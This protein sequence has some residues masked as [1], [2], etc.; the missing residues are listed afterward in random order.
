MFV[1]NVYPFS[2]CLFAVMPIQ[3]LSKDEIIFTSAQVFRKRGYNN[4][5]MADLAEA[6]GLTKGI[7]YHHFENKEELM[8]AVLHG[9]HLHFKVTLFALAYSDKLTPEEKLEKF[10]GKAQKMFSKNDGG[11]LM[12]N[13]ALETLSTQP[14]FAPYLKEFFRGWIDALAAIYSAR[15]QEDAARRIAEQTVQEFEGAVMFL[16]IFGDKRYMDEMLE[17]ARLRLAA[18]C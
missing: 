9:V 12:A 15:Y 14:E 6:C 13:T 11:C 4:T 18:G 16:R 17:R 10:L 7:F 3:K 8:K 2:H 1:L 5:S